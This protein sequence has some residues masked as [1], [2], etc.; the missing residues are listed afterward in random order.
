MALLTLQQLGEKYPVFSKH[1]IS[2]LFRARQKNGLWTTVVAIGPKKLLVD[3]SRFDEWL[4]SRRES[5]PEE[6]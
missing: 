6:G 4:E 3:E 1:T 2:N 5:D